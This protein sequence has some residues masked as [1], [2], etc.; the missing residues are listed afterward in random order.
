VDAHKDGVRCVA[1]TSDGKTLASAGFDGT[2]RIW[3]LRAGRDNPPRRELTGHKGQI[4]VLL[5]TPD[6]SLFAAGES[7]AVYSW[8]AGHDNEPKRLDGCA[9]WVTHL[10][11][12]PDGMALAT[13]G[14]DWT[15]RVWDLA[16]RKELRSVAGRTSACFSPDGKLLATAARTHAIEL[17]DATTLEFRRRLDGHTDTPDGLSF[18]ADGRLLA[19]CGK[20][21]GLRVWDASRGHLLAVP[22]G[23]KGRAWSVALSSDGKT[24]AAGDEDGKLLLWDLSGLSRGPAR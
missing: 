17:L 7:G 23:H 20:D 22:R 5:F 8:D 4:A 11:L 6:G 21:G 10:S 14:N 15:V 18:S 12:T 16:T 3:D 2:I 1:F 13:S 19:S 24:L 9:D